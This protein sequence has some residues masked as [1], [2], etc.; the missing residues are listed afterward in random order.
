M[1]S[2]IKIC[3]PVPLRVRLGIRRDEIL[4][5]VRRALIHMN[6]LRFANEVS[7]VTDP[8]EPIV[9]SCDPGDGSQRPTDH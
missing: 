3:W 9:R 6:T 4:L 1:P 7:F 2:A 8:R 5:A